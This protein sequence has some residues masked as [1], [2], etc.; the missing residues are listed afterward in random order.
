MRDSGAILSSFTVLN[1]YTIY[2]SNPSNL[3]A[4]LINYYSNANNINQGLTLPLM[5]RILGKI[6]KA[7]AQGESYV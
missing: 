7:E 5:I 4:G 2:G 3:Y 6:T 1:A